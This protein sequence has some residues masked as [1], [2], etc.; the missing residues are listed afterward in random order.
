[1]TIRES[2]RGGKWV[3]ILFHYF[4]EVQV[5]LIIVDYVMMGFLWL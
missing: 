4:W 3:G 2:K 1:M 5:K